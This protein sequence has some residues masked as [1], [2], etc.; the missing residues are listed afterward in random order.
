MMKDERKKEEEEEE[1]RILDVYVFK[2]GRGEGDEMENCRK[3]SGADT[4]TT[5]GPSNQP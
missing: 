4:S 3:T 1:K 5:V 2:R